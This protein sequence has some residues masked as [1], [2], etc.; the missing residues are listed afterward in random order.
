[1]VSEWE[2]GPELVRG[3]LRGGRVKGSSL[4][5]NVAEVQQRASFGGSG[6]V[7][8]HVPAASA[9]TCVS[10][11]RRVVRERRAMPSRH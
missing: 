5:A 9:G 7:L 2:N 4:D 11:H 8:G 3:L 10:L 6:V 1:M